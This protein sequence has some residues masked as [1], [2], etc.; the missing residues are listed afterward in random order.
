M[1][2]LPLRR[3]LFAV[4]ALA[5]VLIYLI[6]W[7]TYADI[8]FEPRYSLRPPGESAEVQGSS[9][10]LLSLVRSGKLTNLNRPAP[11]LPDPGAVWIV[12]QVES[13]RHDP[14]KKFYCGIKLLGPEGRLW[15]P[16]I[17]IG[18]STPDCDPDSPVG[19]VIRFDVIYMVP[20]R[21]A[22][23]L[24]GVTLADTSTPARTPVLRPP[25]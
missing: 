24:I 7:V 6:W 22:G 18:R 13:V 10:R 21:Y 9:V 15:S 1:R 14:E 4:A 5:A 17:A 19:Q 3:I 12:G 20:A 16:E 2:A 25:L 23:Q 8:H 11:V